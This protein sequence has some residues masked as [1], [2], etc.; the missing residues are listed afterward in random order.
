[1]LP[2][3]P[4]TST[5]TFM[6]WR[7]STA[8]LFAFSPILVAHAQ[9]GPKN[10]VILI[11]RHAENPANGHGLSP[12]GEERA[13][14]YKNYFLNFTV[15]SKRRE[16]QAIIVRSEEHTSELQSLRH[17]VCRLLLEK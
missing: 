4:R 16:P 1:M 5:M 11:I 12:R 14:A 6:H 9:E 10:S 17:L 7:V 2:I 13:K 15:D 3:N 8:I